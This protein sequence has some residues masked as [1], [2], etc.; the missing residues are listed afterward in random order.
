MN[1]KLGKGEGGGG[2][3]RVGVEG[4]VPLWKPSYFGGFPLFD[5]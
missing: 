5:L 2:E 1:W 4:K 3:A